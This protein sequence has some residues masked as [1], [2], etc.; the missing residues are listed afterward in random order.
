M[1]RAEARGF[2]RVSPIVYISAFARVDEVRAFAKSG[3]KWRTCRVSFGK[4]LESLRTLSPTLSG[5]CGGEV[6]RIE[7]AFDTG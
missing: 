2:D 6:W 3:W 4:R 1:S 5:R 7:M